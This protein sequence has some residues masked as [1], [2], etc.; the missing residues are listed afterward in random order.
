MNDLILSEGE[1][2]KLM[3]VMNRVHQDANSHYTM[4]NHL[5]GNMIAEVGDYPGSDSSIY[6]ALA[7]ATYSSISTMINAIGDQ[8]F[9][10]MNLRGQKWTL[11]IIPVNQSAQL[12]FIFDSNNLPKLSK[13]SIQDWKEKLDEVIAVF[14]QTSKLN[15]DS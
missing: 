7:S 5:A 9:D 11:C 6:S 3:D 4:L 13:T 2:N 8:M 12:I 14:G 15:Y 1:S 10:S